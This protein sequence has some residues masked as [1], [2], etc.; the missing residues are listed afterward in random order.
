MTLQ[1]NTLEFENIVENVENAGNQDFLLFP[2]CFLPFLVLSVS[3]FSTFL[4]SSVNA[5]N[6]DKFKNCHLVTS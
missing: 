5:L 2:P 4:L 3:I 1:R 6:L